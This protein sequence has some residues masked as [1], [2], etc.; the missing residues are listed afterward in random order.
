MA[1]GQKK[2]IR[3]SFSTL[4]RF[5]YG[6]EKRVIFWLIALGGISSAGTFF[7]TMGAVFYLADVP[8][9]SATEVI[10]GVLSELV[11]SPGFWFLLM[12]IGGLIVRRRWVIHEMQQ[13][14]LRSVESKPGFFRVF[15]GDDYRV[16]IWIMIMG[17]VWAGNFAYY[18]APSFFK[19]GL[20]PGYC[21]IGPP[22]RIPPV[23]HILQDALIP[24]AS[25]LM[26][27]SPGGWLLITG[28]GIALVQF[29]RILLRSD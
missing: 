19:S 12:G 10:A 20:P 18:V 1:A 14:V 29:C 13:T 9:E 21:W 22:D 28:A 5:V 7:I 3:S 24:M 15:F 25:Y 4:F 26:T 17:S 11:E 16:A 6:D 8:P 23:E 27:H 2:P